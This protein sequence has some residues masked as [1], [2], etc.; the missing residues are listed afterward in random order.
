MKKILLLLA[1]IYNF[2]FGAYYSAVPIGGGY[3]H[4]SPSWPDVFASSGTIKRIVQ[5][6]CTNY[7]YSMITDMES[8]YDQAYYYTD[9]YLYLQKKYYINSSVGYASC[10]VEYYA[11][12]IPREDMV[13]TPTCTDREK[14]DTDTNTCVEVCPLNMTRKVIESD[15]WSVSQPDFF[16]ENVCFPDSTVSKEDCLSNDGY[17]WAELGEDLETAESVLAMTYGKGCYQIAY[18]QDRVYHQNLSFLVGGLLPDLPVKYL[19]RLGESMF[20]SGKNLYTYISDFFKSDTSVENPSLLTYKPDFIDVDIVDGRTKPVINFD[21]SPQITFIDDTPQPNIIQANDSIPPSDNLYLGEDITVFE[22]NS[23]V[24]KSLLDDFVIFEPPSNSVLY[25]VQTSTIDLPSNLS[26]TATKTFDLETMITDIDNSADL[27]VYETTIKNADNSLTKVTTEKYFEDDGSAFYSVKVETP[28][29]TN[30]GTKTLIKEYEVTKNADGTVTNHN[31]STNSTVTTTTTTGATT[32]T[33][34]NVSTDTTT[35]SQTQPAIDL[36]PVTTKLDE[37]QNTIKE[38]QEYKPENYANYDSKLSDFNLALADWE[39]G[40]N[41]AL[42]FVDGLKSNI[43]DLIN[44]FENLKNVFEDKPTMSVV[45]GTCPFQA[46]WVRGQ[47]ITVNPCEFISPYKPI[48]S[49]FFTMLFT[50]YVFSFSLKYL[51]NVSLGGGK[52]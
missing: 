23:I 13:I 26:K 32:T 19:S 36:T 31:Y 37:L 42:D 48:L 22:S 38:M 44:D 6:D 5:S 34:N 20:T 9:G 4:N 41:S 33:T 16:D 29:K 40:V 43:N 10:T 24:S 25:E 17:V 11:S 52:K 47:T 3:F 30:T 21:P 27:V 46:N 39:V 1:F 12:M 49:L 51:F 14:L 35:I 2:S 18:L 8:S 15:F 45:T 7:G 28:I 50:M